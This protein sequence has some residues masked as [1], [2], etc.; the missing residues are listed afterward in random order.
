MVI[1]PVA[2]VHVGCT[3][4]AT[5]AGTAGGSLTVTGAD[6][7]VQEGVLTSLATTVYGEPPAFTVNVLA[8]WNAPPFKLYSKVPTAPVA[9]AVS[10]VVPPLQEMVPAVAVTP[11]GQPPIT[12]MDDVELLSAVLSPGKLPG[13]VQ[14]VPFEN[15][16]FP[17]TVEGPPMTFPCTAIN[18]VRAEPTAIGS[19]PLQTVIDA[20]PPV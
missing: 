5:G 2:T 18:M 9:V 12:C 10:V 14:E 17:L 13:I 3:T 15:S 6:V 7:A 8:A 4:L 11:S 16:R 19:V 20:P 1:V